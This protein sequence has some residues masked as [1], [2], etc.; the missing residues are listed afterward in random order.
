M[1]HM[2]IWMWVIFEYEEPVLMT[3]QNYTKERKRNE[4]GLAKRLWGAPV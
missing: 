3:H 2:F 4:K 1:D